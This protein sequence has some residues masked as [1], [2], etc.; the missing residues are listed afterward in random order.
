MRH[1]VDR[2]YSY[3]MH[4]Y[5]QTHI[6][7]IKTNISVPDTFEK[8][9]AK[10]DYFTYG[11]YYIEQIN[12]Y[13]EFFPLD[14]LLCLLTD[15]LTGD[16]E[17]LIKSVLRFLEID[18]STDLRNDLYQSNTGNDFTHSLALREIKKLIRSVPILKKVKDSVRKESYIWLSHFSVFLYKKIFSR[19]FQI[20]PPML[21]ETR[22]KLI[23]EF[24]ERNEKLADFLQRDLSHWN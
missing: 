17:H 2:A 6:G 21:P 8:A 19:R 22:E 20:P 7:S 18:D 23:A 10:S 9:I 15:D 16:P 3:Y 12:R 11:S 13:L 5:K 24:Y 14:S 1:P 4:R